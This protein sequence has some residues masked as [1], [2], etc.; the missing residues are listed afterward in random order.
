MRKKNIHTTPLV[1]VTVQ[2]YQHAPFIRTCLDSILMQKTDFPFE[3]I[4]GEDGSTDG[5]KEICQ[6]YA[7]KHPEKIRLFLRS[8]KNVIHI[9]GNPTGRF[10]FIQNIKAATGKYIANCP[11]DDYWIDQYKLQKQVDAI[12]NNNK[13]IACHHWH[14]HQCANKLT[15]ASNDGYYPHKI[16]TVKN[17]FSNQMRVK[18]RTILYKNIINA[19]FFPKWFYE[20]AYGD[21]PFS[22]L[23]GQYG[24]FYFIDEPMAVYRQT[25]NGVSKAGK[26]NKSKSEWTKYHFKKWIE[27]WKYANKHYNFKY[28]KEARAT[29]LSFYKKIIENS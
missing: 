25:A 11:G 3:I 9:D 23:L 22:F 29:I 18:S 21:V 7:K 14:L 6:E 17:I 5:T 15:A 2:T 28:D 24:N 4:L 1:S 8:R 12:K 27:I 10:N 19:F 26:A 13:I 20:V 16:A